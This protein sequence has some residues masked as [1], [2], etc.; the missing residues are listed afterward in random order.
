MKVVDKE[1]TPTT[2]APAAE[3]TP[4]SPPRTTETPTPE[5]KPYLGARYDVAGATTT[6]TTETRPES[7][8]VPQNNEEKKIDIPTYGTQ[9]AEELKKIPTPE[10]PTTETKPTP[11]A[12]PEFPPAPYIPMSDNP[13]SPLAETPTTPTLP[14]DNSEPTVPPG[15]IPEPGMVTIGVHADGSSETTYA[16]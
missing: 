14:I 11:E 10:T 3:T 13:A 8:P 6:P 12:K 4:D 15:T 2:P 16:P 5:S 7:V 9:V 1:E